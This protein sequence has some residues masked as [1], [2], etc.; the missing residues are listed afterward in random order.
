MTISKFKK[1][2]GKKIKVEHP[3]LATWEGM[4]KFVKTANE[5]TCIKLLEMEKRGRK[6]PRFLVRI[7]GRMNLLRGQRERKAFK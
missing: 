7:H 6:R 3:S 2:Y 5:E 4:L 1:H